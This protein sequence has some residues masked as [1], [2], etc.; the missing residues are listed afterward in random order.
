MRPRRFFVDTPL[1]AGQEI[2]LESRVSNHISSVL[3]LRAGDELTLFNGDGGEYSSVITRSIK[4][5]IEV[6]VGARQVTKTKSPLGTH[7]GLVVIKGSLMDYSIQ[8]ATELG[9][10]E[11]TPLLSERCTVRLSEQRKANRLHHWKQISWSSCEQCDWNYPPILHPTTD[12]S[13]WMDAVIADL[14]I[15]L[16]PQADGALSATDARPRTVALA[17]G[18][19][20]GFTRSE[21]SQ[22]S[23]AGFVAK[24]LGPRTLRADTVPAAA[25]TLVQYL[26][27][28]LAAH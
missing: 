15:V 5:D 4:R 24:R 18:P 3:R 6:L 14:K 26:W 19:E 7:L 2:T 23:Q 12:L 22:A 16:L 25:L 27:G 20:G 1:Q 21:M 28:D 13:E 11:I 10:T 17:V 8:K 9:V